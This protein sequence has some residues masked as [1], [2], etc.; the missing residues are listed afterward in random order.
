MKMDLSKSSQDMREYSKNLPH[1]QPKII[2][3]KTI[4]S[5]KITTNNQVT[6]GPFPVDYLDEDFDFAL[7]IFPTESAINNQRSFDRQEEWRKKC[8]Q[9]W[10][11]M[12]RLRKL[13]KKFIYKHK[14]PDSV[15]D[16]WIKM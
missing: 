11:K 5:K 7:F 6:E 3:P 4:F 16:A 1:D 8:E 15:W 10:N 14:K 13:F 9:K 2:I 12:S